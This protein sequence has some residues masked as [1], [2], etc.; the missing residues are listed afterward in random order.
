MK[1]EKYND[2]STKLWRIFNILNPFP[3]RRRTIF[4]Y[5]AK[6]NINKEDR[7]TQ[8]SLKIINTLLI[9]QILVA[10]LALAY[11]LPSI[12]FKANQTN[13]Y[14]IVPAISLFY[15]VSSFMVIFGYFWPQFTRHFNIFGDSIY[16]R[17]MNHICRLSFFEMIVLLG[18]VTGLLGGSWLAVAPLF[19]TGFIAFIIIYPSDKKW[20]KLSKYYKSKM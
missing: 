3:L 10:I 1:S 16:G 20:A 18:F 13:V 19:I 9:I 11:I 2:S 17:F 14:D 15:I 5:F 8:A 6:G 7:I 4:N 12:G